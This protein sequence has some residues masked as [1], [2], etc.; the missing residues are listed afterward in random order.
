MPPMFPSVP[1]RRFVVTAASCQENSAASATHP[2]SRSSGTPSKSASGT[3]CASSRKN[4]R[5]FVPSGRSEDNT[6]NS[7]F[8]SAGA[9]GT[10]PIV[11]HKLV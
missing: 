8:V 5:L 4:A 10:E 2:V 6:S 7:T 1:S 3:G 9:M 11:S